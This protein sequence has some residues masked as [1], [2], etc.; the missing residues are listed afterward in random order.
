MRIE[1]SSSSLSKAVLSGVEKDTRGPETPPMYT[2]F[3]LRRPVDPGVESLVARL[4][5]LFREPDVL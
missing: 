3:F 2:V 1:T 4:K 5:Q